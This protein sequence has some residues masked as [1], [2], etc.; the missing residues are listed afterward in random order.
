MLAIAT[1]GKKIEIWDLKTH[2]RIEQLATDQL[3]WSLALSPDSRVLATGGLGSIKVWKMRQSK[4]DQPKLKLSENYTFIFNDTEPIQATAISST[5][6]IV[7]G[8]NSDGR[9]KLFHLL[10]KATHAFNGHSKVINSIAIDITGT[11]LWSGSEDDTLRLW[12]VRTAQEL[13][14]IQAELG[15]IKTIAIHPSKKIIAAGGNYGA[16]KLWDWH[17][18]K[19]ISSFSNHLVEVTALAFSPD[20][21]TLVAGDRDGKMVTYIAKNVFVNKLDSP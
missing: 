7:I 15:G 13:S 6:P 5:S 21:Q 1:E 19:L 4:P 11:V 17:T 12:N 16:V 8:G 14:T 2:K 10:N 3:I 18:G 20:G 9:I